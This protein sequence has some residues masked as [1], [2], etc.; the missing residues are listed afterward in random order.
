[1]FT[2]GSTAIECGGGLK[3]AGGAPGDDVAFDVARAAAGLEIHGLLLSRD[4][5]AAST[6]SATVTKRAR[7][8]GPDRPVIRGICGALETGPA[9][10][11]A[12]GGGSGD[13]SL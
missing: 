1:M 7:V 2:N 12:M 9:G 3:A 10:N 13:S 4:A 6:N 11:R 8:N 5:S